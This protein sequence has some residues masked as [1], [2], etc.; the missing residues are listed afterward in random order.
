MHMRKNLVR[1]FELS[2]I[3]E[4][5]FESLLSFCPILS[6]IFSFARKLG[7][8]RGDRSVTLFLCFMQG[9]VR[10]SKKGIWEEKAFLETWLPKEAS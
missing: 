2:K 10:D 6:D 5:F 3:F 8:S 1:M 7:N 9:K 4:I